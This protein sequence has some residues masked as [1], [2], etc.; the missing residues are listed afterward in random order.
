MQKLLKA[1]HV[2]G[3]AAVLGA[4]VA[5][6]VL[7]AR[8]VNATGLALAAQRADIAALV[9]LAVLP[10]LAATLVS[11]LLATAINSLY[12]EARW[13]WIKAGLGLAIFEGTLF[14]VGAG[15]RRAAELAAAAAAGQP[16][17]ELAQVLRTQTRGMWLLLAV[18]VVSTLLAVWRPRLRRAVV[19]TGG[20]T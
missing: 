18:A 15:A 10:A 17:A 14:S 13:V 1:T 19:S 20:R 8:A 12:H 6:L 4:L 2:L 16:A 7:D 3:S 9:R 11:G 5:C